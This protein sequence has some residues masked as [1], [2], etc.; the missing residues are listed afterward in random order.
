MTSAP[1]RRW[2]RFSLRTL[3]VVVTVIACW[4][5]WNVH[6][7]RQRQA[8]WREIVAEDEARNKVLQRI[9][10]W[11]G[12]T[13]WR[14]ETVQK[15]SLTPAQI[16]IVRRLLGDQPRTDIMRSREAD[17]RRTMQFFPEATITYY[18]GPIG[19]PPWLD[20]IIEEAFRGTPVTHW[21]DPR[22]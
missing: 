22:P 19:S 2:F 15:G 9:P 4:L 16:P 14:T 8:V 12:F 20:A 7:V 3:F 21:Y 11:G 6:V 18:S 1:K 10:R 13:G 5:G 17:A